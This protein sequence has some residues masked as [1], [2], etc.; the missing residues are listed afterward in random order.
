M[1]V[2]TRTTA[3]LAALLQSPLPDS[4]RRPPP[5]HGRARSRWR[6]TAAVRPPL[7]H[8]RR[9][10]TSAGRWSRSRQA[11]VIVS[12]ASV[13]DRARRA[14]GDL[15]VQRGRAL[16]DCLLQVRT[17]AAAWRRLA[18]A[19]DQPQTAV[20]SGSRPVAGGRLGDAT[21][22]TDS[23]D[24]NDDPHRSIRWHV[25]HQLRANLAATEDVVEKA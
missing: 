25:R 6:S 24:R 10:A 8:P 7:S 18:V 21:F 5:Y 9:A 20:L 4:N 3:T 17:C 11:E 13:Q 2:A 16:Q 14:V 19:R 12:S 15:R 23:T 22:D 1:Q